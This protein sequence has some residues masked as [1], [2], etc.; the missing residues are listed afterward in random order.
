MWPLRR[1]SRIDPAA[2]GSTRLDHRLDEL[3]AA[4][5]VLGGRHPAGERVGGA[6]LPARLDLFGHVAVEL[7]KTFE[8]TLGM[9]GRDARRACRRRAGTGTAAGDQLRPAAQRREPE[10]VGILLR[11]RQARL[12]AVHTDTQPVLVAGRDLAGP[13]HASR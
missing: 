11:E 1:Q 9:T 4:R 5:A 13:E 10:L 2:V 12:A 3:H 8:V 7:S 6:L